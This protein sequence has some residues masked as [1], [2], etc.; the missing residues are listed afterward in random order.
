MFCCLA[1]LH[2]NAAKHQTHKEQDEPQC[3]T[4]ALQKSQ[5]V[6]P[7]LIKK[8]DNGKVKARL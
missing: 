3:I 2:Q 5:L 8:R 6:D 1:N 4:Q 7:E